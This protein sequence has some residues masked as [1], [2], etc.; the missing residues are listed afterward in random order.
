MMPRLSIIIPTFNRAWCIRRAVNSALWQ[1]F[2]DFELIIVDDGSTDETQDILA[3]YRDSRIRILRHDIN[4]GA[5]AAI[6]TGIRA[7]SG[8][9]IAIL[10]SNDEWLPEKMERQI[11]VLD[12]A[13]PDVGIIY[14]DMWQCRGAEREYYRAPH[15]VPP[16]GIIDQNALDDAFDNIGNPLMLFRRECFDKAGLFDES[17]PRQIE[18]DI[19][20]RISRYFKF[21]HIPEPLGTHYV[22]EESATPD[23]GTAG[24]SAVEQMV[25]KQIDDFLAHKPLYARQMYWI[26]TSCM[27]SGQTAKGRQ[28]LRLALNYSWRPRYVLAFL[29]SFLG[30][31]PYVAMHRLG[32][33]KGGGA[34]IELD[35]IANPKT[36]SDDADETEKRSAAS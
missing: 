14:G 26:G 29:L 9:L 20:I 6:N 33:E 4:K 28:Y 16:D 10:Y 12:A 23:G 7:S 1:S 8:E 21:Q 31:R 19:A 18:L 32:P 15:I 34:D 2:H 24:M 17:L 30:Q 13:G 22:S 5:G 27:R 3:E 11:A 35:R 25:A 36:V